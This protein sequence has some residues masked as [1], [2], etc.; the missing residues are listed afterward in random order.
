MP[1]AQDERTPMPP[2]RAPHVAPE[3]FP[4][5]GQH[6]RLS[7]IPRRKLVT[8]LVRRQMLQKKNSA[9]HLRRFGESL[10][11]RRSL[12]NLNCDRY[13]ERPEHRVN[14]VSAKPAA[15]SVRVKVSLRLFARPACRTMSN[16]AKSYIKIFLISRRLRTSSQ[17]S[18]HAFLSRCL[19]SGDEGGGVSAIDIR[20]NGVSGSNLSQA[21]PDDDLHLCVWGGNR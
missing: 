17:S 9:T 13:S 1:T 3:I 20:A 4:N 2:R 5:R 7:V 19:G 6:G 18:T 14:P 16:F 15:A 11:Q 12:A 10:Q 8:K 21:Q